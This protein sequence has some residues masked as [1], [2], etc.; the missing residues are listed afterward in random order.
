MGCQFPF[1][2]FFLVSLNPKNDR[3]DNLHLTLT[4]YN[5]HQEHIKHMFWVGQNRTN[6]HTVYDRIYGDFYAKSTV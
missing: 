6:T 3:T 1:F 5:L 4:T 2:A